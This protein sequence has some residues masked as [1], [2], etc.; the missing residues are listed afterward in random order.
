[1]QYASKNQKKTKQLTYKKI[2]FQY[3]T[4]VLEELWNY[5]LLF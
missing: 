2:A 4:I 1:M 5:F 3:M